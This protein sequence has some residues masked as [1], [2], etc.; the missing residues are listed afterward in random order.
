MLNDCAMSRD[1]KMM[2]REIINLHRVNCYCSYN[3]G[4][5]HRTH[6]HCPNGC[7]FSKLHINKDYNEYLIHIA[8][9]ELK[10]H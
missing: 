3:L 2:G 6:C 7:L 8:Y 5:E 10:L 4:A 9:F 1:R